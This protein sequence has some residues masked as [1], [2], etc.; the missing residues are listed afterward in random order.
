MGSSHFPDTTIKYKTV[1]MN[2][3]H[4]LQHDLAYEIKFEVMTEPA[5]LINN[6]GSGNYSVSGLMI[7]IRRRTLSFV[8]NFFFPS[9]LIV[10]VSFISFWIPPPS[11]PGRA[12]VWE[13]VITE[14][15]DVTLQ[16]PFSCGVNTEDI[17]YVEIWLKNGIFKR[18]HLKKTS[19]RGWAIERRAEYCDAL[20]RAQNEKKN[21]GAN[22]QRYNAP[23]SMSQMH[24][25]FELFLR[26]MTNGSKNIILRATHLLTQ[27]KIQSNVQWPRFR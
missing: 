25:S 12:P 2:L 19:Y 24:D 16:L 8:I 26:A 27:R 5:D 1:G 9:F 23:Y 22:W 20:Q 4:G 21:W 3:L 17:L 18:V 6:F 11:I 14:F 15:V 13:Q 7:S 10:L